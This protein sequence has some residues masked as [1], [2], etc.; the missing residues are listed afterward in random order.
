MGKIFYRFFYGY[1]LS[2]RI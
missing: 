2:C 1:G